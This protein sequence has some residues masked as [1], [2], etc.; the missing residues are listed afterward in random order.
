VFARPYRD[1]FFSLLRAWHDLRASEA[2]WC[3]FN[4]LLG[5]SIDPRQAIQN[6][7]QSP[8]NVGTKIQLGDFSRDEAWEL[9]RRYQSPLKRQGHVEALMGV[10]GGHPYLLQQALYVLATRTAG[11]PHLLNMDDADNG[12]FADHLQHYWR[13]LDSEPTLRQGMQQAIT[14]GTCADYGVFLHLRALGL[15]T[16]ASHRTVSP[17][18]RLYATYFQRVLS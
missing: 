10:I 7:D 17:R 13:I 6:L 16:G 8:F 12:P 3:R 11:L 5:Y 18:C 1:D 14:N 15:V 9:N 4:L 2:L